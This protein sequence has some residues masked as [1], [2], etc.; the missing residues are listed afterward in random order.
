MNILIL[1]KGFFGTRINNFLNKQENIHSEIYS[2][3]E[4]DY[5]NFNTLHD[6]IMFHGQSYPKYDVVI[7]ASG[8]TGI[9][10]IDSAEDNMEECYYNNVIVPLNI[11]KACSELQV[12]MIHLSSGCI[13]N[14]YEKHFTEEDTPNFGMFTAESSFYSKTKHIVEMYLSDKACWMLR[15]RMPF[16]GEDVS[17]NLLKK[18]MNYNNL[19]SM[20]NSLT[21]VDDFCNFL[22]KMLNMRMYLPYGKYNVVN[23]GYITAKDIVGI[24]AECGFVNPNHVFIPLDELGTKARRSNCILSTEKIKSKNLELP[25]VGKSIKIAIKQLVGESSWPERVLF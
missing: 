25:P 19:I 17:R 11:Y 16:C 1:G 15:L 9:P 21:S 6:A 14:G 12:P 5:C 18:I 8:Y 10:N 20:D 23:E 4:L 24:L 7:N 2:R 13:Y 22:L 3:K